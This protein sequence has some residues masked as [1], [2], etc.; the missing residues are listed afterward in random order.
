MLFTPSPPSHPFP[1][2]VK[3]P[4]KDIL[5]LLANYDKLVVIQ[6]NSLIQFT[7]GHAVHGYT[8]FNKSVYK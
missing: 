8:R 4:C 2:L 1:F 5:P 3:S 7:E 6:I